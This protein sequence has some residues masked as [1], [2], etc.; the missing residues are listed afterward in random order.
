MKKILEKF[1]Q[2]L[3]PEGITCIVCGAELTRDNRYSMCDTC[4][5]KL[6]F[7]Q[8]SCEKCGREIYDDS[9]FCFDCE[10]SGAKYDKVYSVL[11][12]EGVVSSLIYRLKYDGEKYL[13]KYL[14]R[15]MVDKLRQSNVNFDIIV[16]VPLNKNRLKKR[17]FNQAELLATYIAKEMN[18]DMA[19]V[20]ERVVDTPFQ[21]RLTRE[22]RLNNLKDAFVVRDKTLVKGKT[23]LVIDDI[24]TT[25]STINECATVLFKAKA[26]S[27]IAI[28]LSH[29]KKKFV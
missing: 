5:S 18:K 7:T 25:G 3:A 14:A 4:L 12:Y 20:M 24:F 11:N 8:K 17:G 22:E 28:T 16:P 9:K 23:V 2:A 1:W 26:K 21:A 10:G 15:F 19:N 6:P 27:V 13:A 29:A